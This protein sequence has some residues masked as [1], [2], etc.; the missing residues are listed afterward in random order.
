MK[1]ARRDALNEDEDEDPEPG[2]EEATYSLLGDERFRRFALAKLLQLTAKNAFVYGLFISYITEERSYLAGSSFILASVLPTVFLSVPGGIV[3]D[4]LPNKV[5]L[6]GSL[7]VRMFLIW[8]FV[9]ASVSIEQVIFLTFFS[10]TAFQF[11]APAENEA[12]VAVAP[13]E[14]MAAATA[15]LQALSLVS[16]ILG[17][18]A[19]APLTLDVLGR[20]AFFV[21]VLLLMSA[22]TLLYLA[23]PHLTPEKPLRS[24]RLGWWSALPAGYR[25]LR[26]DR[27]LM[28]LTLLRVLV[29]TS[30]LMVLVAAP[31]FIEE[32]LD[33]SAASAVY[34][35]TPAALG[36]ALGLVITPPLTRVV[37]TRAIA[38][39]G[40]V[41]FTGVLACLAFIE[42]LSEP[43]LNLLGWWDAIRDEAGLSREIAT[44]IVLLP[45]AGMGL[46]LVQVSARAEVY[47]RVR[48]GLL[49]QVLATQSAAGS[50][51]AVIPTF[52][53]G[54]LLDLLPVS[55]FLGALVAASVLAAVA[56]FSTIAQATLTKS[57]P[58][59]YDEGLA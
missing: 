7:L 41:L 3:A 17:A 12:L 54:A 22:S 6:A 14:K 15:V 37:R 1:M 33:A 26:S 9:G 2:L 56:G 40:Y 43:I 19:V 34:I 5:V 36:L 58:T 8:Q 20:D 23:V 45:F 13:H 47:E 55:V 53:A 18:G 24:V 4:R 51:V 16:Q 11:F 10:W 39:V 50:L 25:M 46:S 49:G 48:P 30:M 28:R 21:T 44:A 35:G 59:Q 32:T 57:P 29:D 31:K 38:L 52:L 27:E 42:P